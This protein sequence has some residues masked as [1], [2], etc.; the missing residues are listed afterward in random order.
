MQF[1]TQAKGGKHFTFCDYIGAYENL[2]G[3]YRQV[4]MLLLTVSLNWIKTPLGC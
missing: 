2:A 4:I 3:R 1:N